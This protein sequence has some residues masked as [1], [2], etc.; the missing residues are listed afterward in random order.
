MIKG[1]ED[2]CKEADTPEALE[3]QVEM[4]KETNPKASMASL[5]HTIDLIKRYDLR[6]N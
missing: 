1:E 2:T 6:E 3:E 4:S 5:V